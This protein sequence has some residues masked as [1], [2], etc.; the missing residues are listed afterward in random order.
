MWRLRSFTATTPRVGWNG[1]EKILVSPSTATAELVIANFKA[2][3]SDRF[4]QLILGFFSDQRVE[5]ALH[6]LIKKCPHLVSFTCNLN[7]HSAVRQVA[8]PTGHVEA[9]GDMAY[10]ETKPNAL[11]ATFVKYLKRDHHLLQD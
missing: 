4:V 6:D 1:T 7:F 9:L 5:F 10:S 11:D 2:P 3:G 8:H